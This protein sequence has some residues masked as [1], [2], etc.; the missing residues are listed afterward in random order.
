MSWSAAGVT[1]AV[2]ESLACGFAEAASERFRPRF[3]TRAW[4]REVPGLYFPQAQMWA[5]AAP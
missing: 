5:I 2:D 4:R 1:E 3:Q